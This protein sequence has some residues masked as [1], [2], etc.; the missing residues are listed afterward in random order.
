M[1]RL[2]VVDSTGE[3]RLVIARGEALVGRRADV[4]V[5]I[6]DIRVPPVQCVLRLR[7]DRLAVKDLGSPEGT[8]LNGRRIETAVL[9]PGNELAVGGARIRID[10]IS[11]V[12]AGREFE[13][14]IRRMLANAPWY[15]ISL[16]V[17]LLLL[18]LLNLATVPAARTEI[19]ARMAAVVPHEQVGPLDFDSGATPVEP[20]IERAPEPEEVAPHLEQPPSAAGGADFATPSELDRDSVTGAGAGLPSATSRIPALSVPS[21]AKGTGTSL[22]GTPE[23]ENAKARDTVAGSLGDGLGALRTLA[24]ENIVVVAGD[25][26]RIEK[27]LDLYTIPYTVRNQAGLLRDPLR[28]A[29]I[30]FINCGRRP[31]APEGRRRAAAKVKSFVDSGGWLVTSDWAI[32]P[33]LTEGFSGRVAVF[34]HKRNQRNT[35]VAVE[36]TAIDNPLLRQVFPPRVSSRWWLED[37]ST[38]FRVLDGDLVKT[39]VRSA[40]LQER[41]GARDVV[42]EFGSGK[43]RVLHLLGHFYQRHESGNREGVVSMHRLV[44]NFVLER[45]SAPK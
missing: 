3:R 24:P 9:K 23:E 2:T 32:E 28:S 30:I 15:L 31:V 27:V 20:V 12:V 41:F 25:Y 44:L 26:D 1:I 5:R 33:Y 36:A 4:D 39:L 14:E 13:R 10:A 21:R 42:I 40:E 37:S 38:M 11:G 19:G 16:A 45:F 43:G 8:W 17:H 29:R 22:T 18:I 6:E 7:G 34:D 35:S